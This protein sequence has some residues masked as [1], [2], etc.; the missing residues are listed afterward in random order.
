[1]SK[2]LIIILSSSVSLLSKLL[3]SAKK[4]I[5]QAAS[6]SLLRNRSFVF[7]TFQ[8][9]FLFMM[10]SHV[11]PSISLLLLMSFC[12][13][14]IVHRIAI[15]NFIFIIITPFVLT[16]TLSDTE[17][18]VQICTGKIFICTVLFLWYFMVIVTV[19]L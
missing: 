6:S 9:H 10:P 11:I 18:L 16:I 12:V 1:M 15:I 13:G 19:S 17:E 5:N 8:F 7:Y 3:L 2:L 4:L 14:V